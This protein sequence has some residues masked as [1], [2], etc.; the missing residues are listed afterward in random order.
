MKSGQQQQK[1]D[2][3]RH[4]LA[5][6]LAA[7]VRSLYP[8]A[9]NAIG[10]AIENG[11]YQDFDMGG[12]TITNEDFPKIE[13]HMRELLSKW[14][15]FREWPVTPD[16]ARLAMADNPYKLELID[17][18]AQDGKNITLNDPGNFVDLCKGGHSAD[19][20]S[21]LKHFKLLSVAGAYWKGSEKNQMLTRIYGTA[22]AS[23][24]ELTAHLTLLEDAKKRDHK[25]LG[26]E[27][28]LFTFSEN[29]GKG[30]P[31]WTPKGSALRRVLERFI[32]DEEIKRGYLH[33]YTP[34]I[35]NLKLYQKSGHYPYYKDSMYAPITIDDEEFMLRPMTCP[36]HFEL[37]NSRPR[38]YKELPMRIAEIA[39]L[40]RY[41]KSGELMGL[42][43]VRAFS[44]TDAHIVAR[45]SQAEQVINE[46]FDLIE[47]LCDLFGLKMGK[48]YHYRLSLG[49]RADDTK[50]FKDDASWDY[51]ESTLRKVLVDRKAVFVEAPNEAAFYGPKVD[52]QM[53]NANGKE[54]TAFTNQYDFVMP[55]R[56]DMKFTNE[57]GREEEPI[58]IHRASLGAIERT[59]A[60]LIEHFAGAFPVW[61][62]PVQVAVI[63]ITDDQHAYAEQIYEKL[64]A[65]GFRVEND[66]ESESLQKRIR[67]AEKQK[68]PYMLIIGGKE[69]EGQT[70]S[71]RGR[72]QQDFGTMPLDQ[73]QT[74]LKG[75]IDTK[76]LG[77]SLG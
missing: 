50:Y 60:F 62:A 39:H 74:K 43:R 35:A 44:L 52:V 31:L 13:K 24:E 12:A 3:L 4:S 42:L 57:E 56:F 40:Y 61:L 68:I 36:H 53:K 9:R 6:L 45:K 41:E 70:V 38:S 22:F 66:N 29:V 17:D 59:V 5:H 15:D 20:R 10:P 46:V 54:D 37:Y 28:D 69:V 49:S 51:A 64:K 32:I 34:D 30:L 11:F 16:E 65:A 19:P 25:K 21:T 14:Q 58:V 73:F 1:L 55:K 8:T 71:V 18:F 7:S 27:L 26:V 77:L 23:K 47:Y 2:Q 63:P 48:N 33:V 67:Q 72:G 75:L 76:S